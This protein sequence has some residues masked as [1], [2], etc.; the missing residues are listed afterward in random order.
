MIQY[1][2]GLPCALRDG[3]DLSPVSPLKRS[4]MQSGRARQR[5]RFTSVPTM[6]SVSWIMNDVQ[7]Q[8][9]EAWFRDALEDGA[10]WFEMP[11]KTPEGERS[12]TARFTDIYSG[13]TLTGKSNWK[14][15]AQLELRERPILAPGWGLYAPDY[16]LMSAIF[17]K[18]MNFEWPESRYQTYMGEFDRGVNQEWP[19]DGA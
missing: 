6:A 17:D 18:A 2:E 15:T 14:F 4:E 13:P 7:G 16:V 3:Y 11:L 8:L 12:Y 9:F 19:N 10:L 5:R 1:P